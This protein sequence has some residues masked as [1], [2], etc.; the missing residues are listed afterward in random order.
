MLLILNILFSKGLKI[1]ESVIL[2]IY[3]SISDNWVTNP[4]FNSLPTS[5]GYIMGSGSVVSSLTEVTACMLKFGNIHNKI[6]FMQATQSERVE[7]KISYGVGGLT[8]LKTFKFSINGLDGKRIIGRK[9]EVRVYTSSTVYT[10]RFVGKASLVTI[11]SLD[12]EVTV[13]GTF[14]NSNPLL[15]GK[16]YVD[17]EGKIQNSPLILGMPPEY[18]KLDKYRSSVGVGLCYD[19]RLGITDIYVK[20]K[21]ENNFYKTTTPF[22]VKDSKIIFQD[23]KMLYLATALTD[24]STEVRVHDYVTYLITFD[25]ITCPLDYTDYIILSNGSYDKKLTKIREE[26]ISALYAGD[27]MLSYPE[28]FTGFRDKILD[29]VTN[30]TAWTSSDG[31]TKDDLINTASWF[32]SFD[33]YAIEG[34]QIPRLVT[35]NEFTLSDDF[36]L[37]FGERNYREAVYCTP[38]VPPQHPIKTEYL[39]APPGNIVPKDQSQMILKVGNEEML[40]LYADDGL[41]EDTQR[42]LNV[43]RGFNNTEIVAHSVDDLVIVLN[44]KNSYS[45]SVHIDERVRQLSNSDSE[46]DPDYNKWTTDW[47]DGV[48]Y[49][50]EF[51]I[52]N[53]GNNTE[54]EYLFFNPTIPDLTISEIES[55]YIYSYMRAYLQGFTE[56]LCLSIALAITEDEEYSGASTSVD[57]SLLSNRFFG[58]NEHAIVEHKNIHKPSHVSIHSDYIVI[59]RWEQYKNNFTWNFSRAPFLYQTW[60]TNT[61][62]IERREG[63]QIM[64]GS[65]NMSN[66]P[67]PLDTVNPSNG[68]IIISYAVRNTPLEYENLQEIQYALVAIYPYLPAYQQIQAD[69]EL[70]LRTVIDCKAPISDNDW[71]A[72]LTSLSNEIND[73]T[74]IQTISIGANATIYLDNDSYLYMESDINPFSIYDISMT[75]FLSIKQA[76]PLTGYSDLAAGEIVEID[77]LICKLSSG[78][79]FLES[80]NYVIDT[81]KIFVNSVKAKI[82]GKNE[83]STALFIYV[84]DGT[85]LKVYKKSASNAGN[86]ANILK[87]LLL[88]YDIDDNPSDPFDTSY[89]FGKVR[90]NRALDKRTLIINKPTALTTILDSFCKNCGLVIYENNE[91]LISLVDLQVN[92]SV[93]ELT[94]NDSNTLLNSKYIPEVRV[95]TL[96]AKYLISE[97]DIKYSP[98]EEKFIKE[99]KSD[100]LNAAHI[101]LLESSISYGADNKVVF[102]CNTTSDKNIAL[103]SALTLLSYHYEPSDIYYIKTPISTNLRIGSK[104]IRMD[105]TYLVIGVKETLPV[106]NKLAYLEYELLR[107]S[108]VSAIQEVYTNDEKI[109]EVVTNSDIIQEIIS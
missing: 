31:V 54:R 27:V 52:H 10:T 95:K 36:L 20:D 81:T 89:S 7:G 33:I 26:G 22:E 69:V 90:V 40:I 92:D 1:M 108:S 17:V 19:D 5:V 42:V 59:D 80:T 77:S 13:K 63:K 87:K 6:D 57:K 16:E 21:K 29:K 24:N 37:F 101:N 30:Y 51:I 76:I 55:F 66:N 93:V 86:P 98:L 68:R 102:H 43:V 103:S 106:G 60:V 72:K 41:V 109:Q 4:L 50:W 39:F 8:K 9:I 18:V 48:Y 3:P 70:V 91:G 45:P 2:I 88:N 49:N 85:D 61:S 28:V 79:V 62:Q 83:V 104:V 35:E 44:S 12:T 23:A 105:I 46:P 56:S 107:D 32:E 78:F 74:L 75:G 38:A 100:N 53:N 99:V 65:W 58:Y 14:S 73:A 64:I 25:L 97:L 15:V 94:I 82:L 34:I 96:E 71:Y 47:Q 67:Y 84:I 11:R